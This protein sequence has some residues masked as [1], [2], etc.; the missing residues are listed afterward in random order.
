M[1]WFFRDTN[2]VCDLIPSKAC[3]FVYEIRNLINGRK[4]I[5]QKQFWFYTSKIETKIFKNG[6]SKKV[7]VKKFYESDWKDYYGSSTDLNNDIKLYGIESFKREI[8]KICF[9][10]NELNYFETKMIMID[11]ALESNHY[12]NKWC[13][14][15]IT[16]LVR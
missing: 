3:G 5:G 11:E 6:K 12:Y 4:Y 2:L 15:R 13:N 9:S 16:K 1:T 10:K 8:I 14:A 7:K